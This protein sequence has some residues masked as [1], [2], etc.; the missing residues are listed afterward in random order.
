MTP[1][2]NGILRR[3]VPRR[4]FRAPA[5]VLIG[6]K[7][8]VQRAYQLG[9]GGMMVDCKEQRLKEGR[10]LVLS[11]FLPN[12]GLVMVRGIVRGIIPAKD[13]QPERYGVEFLNLG[14]QHKR[15]I[16]NFVAAATRE[17]GP[18]ANSTLY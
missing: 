16:R 18:S 12:Q 14:F 10:N 1:A 13:G 6:G 17:D 11:F 7:Y 5:G 8:S 3:R 2:N 15:A 4:T 9:E